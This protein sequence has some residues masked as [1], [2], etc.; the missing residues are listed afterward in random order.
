MSKREEKKVSDSA[1]VTSHLMMPQDAN[2]QGNV[3]GGAIMKLVDEIA[4]SVAT[5]HTKKNCVTASID[6]MNFFEPVYVGN[7]LILKASIN[8]VGRTSMEIGVRIE[9]RD[10]ITDKVTHTGSSYL[11]FVAL[12]ENKRP[13]TVP[14]IIPETEADKKRYNE[15]RQRR[16]MRLAAAGKSQ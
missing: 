6:Q 16:A 9:A 4:G 10:L 13:T 11:T 15:A 8:Y 14:V 1:L 12:D 3:F 5:I 7:L 2:F